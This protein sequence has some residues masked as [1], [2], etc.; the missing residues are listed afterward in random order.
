[1]SAQESTKRAITESQRKTI[2]KIKYHQIK[3]MQ[4]R[5]YNISQFDQ[6][7]LD[8]YEEVDQEHRDLAFHKM[9][10]EEI[11]NHYYSFAMEKYKLK[12]SI[13][14]DDNSLTGMMTD[15][16]YHNDGK[17]ALVWYYPTPPVRT[18]GKVPKLQ[19]TDIAK[20]VDFYKSINLTLESKINLIITISEQPCSA[21][22][23][24][25]LNECTNGIYFQFFVY[26][27][28][29]YIPARSNL[30]SLHYKLNPEEVRKLHEEEG[31]SS[32]DLPTLLYVNPGYKKSSKETRKDPPTDPIVKWYD[33][34]IGDIIQ[35]TTIITIEE[36]A[37]TIDVILRSVKSAYDKR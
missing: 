11:M 24:D 30:V 29:M 4:D 3:M 6:Q 20:L 2:L 32:R 10:T 27:E 28:L 1:M 15:V 26:D 9:T 23:G 33:Y 34:R 5:G 18:S 21:K 25:K 16:Y 22:M 35:T 7:I 17:T 37:N 12:T 8:K 19:T 13:V 36:T 31:I 14:K